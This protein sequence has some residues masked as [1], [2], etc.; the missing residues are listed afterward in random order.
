MK[1]VLKSIMKSSIERAASLARVVIFEGETSVKNQSAK[2]L[3]PN[4]KW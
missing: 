4:Y 2:L 1:T 3:A